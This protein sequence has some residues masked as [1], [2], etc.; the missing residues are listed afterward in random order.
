MRSD[1]AGLP[2]KCLPIMHGV[3][4]LIIDMATT[5]VAPLWASRCST[6]HFVAAVSPRAPAL[7][8]SAIAM[9]AGLRSFILNAT[10]RRAGSPSLCS[11]RPLERRSAHE[12]FDERRAEPHRGVMR[13]AHLDL[14]EYVL[15]PGLAPGLVEI[16]HRAADVEEGDHLGAV[17]R[18]DERMDL[19]RRLVNEAPFLR[20]PIVLEVA[21]AALDHV[22]DD[23]HR[24]AVP[25]QHARAAHAQQVAPAAGHGV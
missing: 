19:A 5:M 20:G 10:S 21:P 9:A 15:V 18:N 17:A 13:P 14:A 16:D 1:S 25:V 11:S 23:G 8:Q 4:S 2:P 3:P 12:L 6:S 24:M 22:A 7:S